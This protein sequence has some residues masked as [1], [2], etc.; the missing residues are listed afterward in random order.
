MIPDPSVVPA[1][2]RTSDTAAKAI[3]SPRCGTKWRREEDRD[4]ELV[5]LALPNWAMALF[6]RGVLTKYTSKNFT[7]ASVNAKVGPGI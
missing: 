1:C 4:Q 5:G 7:L 6:R 3:P 2:T